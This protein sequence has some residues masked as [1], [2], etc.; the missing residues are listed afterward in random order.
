VVPPAAAADDDG[1]G[2]KATITLSLLD[3]HTQ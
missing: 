3:K 2:V 1:G